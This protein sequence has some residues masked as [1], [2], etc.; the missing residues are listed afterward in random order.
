MVYI[1]YG[2]DNLKTR[3]N[4]IGFKNNYFVLLILISI[5]KI[6]PLCNFI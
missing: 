4:K 6:N 5:V 1:V 2:M 3:L